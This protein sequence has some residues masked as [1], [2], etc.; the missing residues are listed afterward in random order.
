MRD[1]AVLAESWA[2]LLPAW[3]DKR[4]A[5][6]LGLVQIA[7]GTAGL[8]YGA[9]WYAQVERMIDVRGAVVEASAPRPVTATSSEQT[10]TI[11]ATYRGRVYAAEITVRVPPDAPVQVG[12]P[13]RATLI[14]D[15]PRSLRS[16][17]TAMHQT[18]PVAALAAAGL[19]AL[20]GVGFLFSAIL[21]T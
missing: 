1:E 7:L 20:V 16:G 21:R 19:F 8:Q 12:K 13:W 5:L 17:T 10:L 9:R 6:V 11:A 3:L 2:D 4:T 18:G 14:P 15:E